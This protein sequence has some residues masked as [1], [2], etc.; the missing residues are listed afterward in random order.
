[1]LY[2]VVPIYIFF[3]YCLQIVFRDKN[4]FLFLLLPA[5]FFILIIG[6]FRDITVGTD[7]HMYAFV[8]QY[9]ENIEIGY[10]FLAEFIK[11]FGG[12]F[13]FFLGLFFVFSFFLKLMSFKMTSNYFSLSL[14]TYSG[15][16]FMT[17]DINGIRQGLAL[18]FVIL[19]ISFLNRENTKMFYFLLSLAIINH[20]SSV[21]VIPFAI[22]VNK[23]KCTNRLF[24]IIFFSIAL[25]AVSQFAQ[26]II[27]FISNFFGSDN[28]LA[29]KAISYSKD[30]LYNQNVLYS[31]RTL[32]R[33]F[34]LFITFFSL[35]KL[36]IND[37]LKNII[38][39]SALLN[40]SI[41]LIFSQ[42]EIIATRLSLYYRFT[43]CIFFSFLPELT[44]NYL[45]KVLIGFVLLCYILLQIFQVLSIENNNLVPYKSILF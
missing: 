31:S 14:L 21:I 13:S 33:I 2:Y 38:L 39:W 41:Y 45:I 37:R 30:K 40:V 17:Y 43:E 26:P 6:V 35:Q 25:L 27:N 42:F 23:I 15:F 20:Y 24:L 32:V 29:L 19:A 34:I 7:T 4:K 12:S 10:K 9:P 8:F 22:I 44:K 3:I 5:I 1:M 36:K 18:G 11:Y 16:W 28:H